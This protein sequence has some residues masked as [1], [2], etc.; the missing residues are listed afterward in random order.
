MTSLFDL[1]LDLVQK[2]SKPNSRSKSKKNTELK[3]RKEKQSKQK[4]KVEKER[5]NSHSKMPRNGQDKFINDGG[6]S[7]KDPNKKDPKKDVTS[8]PLKKETSNLSGWKKYNI[9]ALVP[10]TP[11]KMLID[12]GEKKSKEFYVV[13]SP[14]GGLLTD[15]PYLMWQR[16][17]YQAFFRKAD[18]CND[19]SKC[20]N[21]FPN[22]LHC[23]F[24]NNNDKINKTHSKK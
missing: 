19:T 11:Y 13:L 23:K 7:T 6:F 21:G 4:D 20:P 14:Y 5:N 1:D 9:N 18:R 22:C 24:S 3:H 2:E 17:K 15:E 10:D 12:F 16:K 8:Q